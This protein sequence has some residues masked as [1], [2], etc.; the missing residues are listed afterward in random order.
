MAEM[1]R[2]IAAIG[3][4]PYETN[5]QVKMGGGGPMAGVFAKMGNASMSTV[6]DSVDTGSLS[7]DV[8]APPEDYK[9]NSKR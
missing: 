3:G 1:Y 5:L 9:L 2:Q 7:D 8:F 4:I 6:V